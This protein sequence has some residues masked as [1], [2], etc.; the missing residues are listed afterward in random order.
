M[1]SILNESRNR[2]MYATKQRKQKRSMGNLTI[3]THS[4]HVRIYYTASSV[5][6]WMCIT[7]EMY[8]VLDIFIHRIMSF[9]F[10]PKVK[11]LQINKKIK[12]SVRIHSRWCIAMDK[13]KNKIKTY[14]NVS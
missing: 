5:L 2:E 3:Y 11:W 14:D 8:I 4:Q 6:S 13:K 1:K 12:K 7:M 9:H 10:G